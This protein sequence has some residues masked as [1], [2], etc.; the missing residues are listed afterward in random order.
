MQSEVATKSPA[1]VVLGDTV[2]IREHG[3]KLRK[4]TASNNWACD[5][6]NFLENGCV[7]R[8]DFY[9][10]HVGGERM[11]CDDCDFDSCNKCSKFSVFML[12]HLKAFKQNNQE[13][14][15]EWSNQFVFN[16]NHLQSQLLIYSEP[17]TNLVLVYRC[18][19]IF[20]SRLLAFL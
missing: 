13:E 20:V 1:D 6:R 17:T 10:N 8:Y 19:V 16:S 14:T 11:R 4:V 18:I 2:R 12:L 3:C 5:M 15:A 7:S 9:E